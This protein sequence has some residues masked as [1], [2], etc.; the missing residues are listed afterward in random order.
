MRRWPG[1]ILLPLIGA[2]FENG[3]FGLAE[4]AFAAQRVIEPGLEDAV[5]VIDAGV[6]AEIDGVEAPAEAFPAPV[7]PRTGDKVIEVAGIVYFQVGMLADKT[8]PAR[9][10]RYASPDLLI[11][12]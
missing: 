3:G 1:V 11:I 4:R 6:G 5:V 8:L 12:D 7:I 10:R 2:G 9:L